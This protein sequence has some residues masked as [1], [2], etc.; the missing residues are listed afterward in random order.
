MTKDHALR[1]WSPMPFSGAPSGDHGYGVIDVKVTGGSGFIGPGN[2][3]AWL[4]WTS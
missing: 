3:T 2:G 1:S 4:R